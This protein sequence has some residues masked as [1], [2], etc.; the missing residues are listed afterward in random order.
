MG[1]MCAKCKHK[2]L[3]SDEYPCGSCIHTNILVISRKLKDHYM[4]DSRWNYTQR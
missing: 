4:Y 1:I 2:E 3:P